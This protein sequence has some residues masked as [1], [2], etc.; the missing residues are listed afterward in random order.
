M[1]LGQPYAIKESIIT[2]L[3]I[4]TDGNIVEYYC[5]TLYISWTQEHLNVSL[6]VLPYRAILS[7]YKVIMYEFKDM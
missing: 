6:F 4:K 1:V 7:M 2:R 3:S 5:L